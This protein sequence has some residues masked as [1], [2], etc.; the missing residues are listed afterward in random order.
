MAVNLD[1]F[2]FQLSDLTI[3]RYWLSAGVRAVKERDA[4]KGMLVASSGIPGPDDEEALHGKARAEA[5]TERRI[6]EMLVRVSYVFAWACLE[7]LLESC[8]REVLVAE[9]QRVLGIGDWWRDGSLVRRQVLDGW[10]RDQMIEEL[11]R[12]AVDNYRR[13]P[14]PDVPRYFAK[15]LDVPWDREWEERLLTVCRRRNSAAHDLSFTSCHDDLIEKELRWVLD[16]GEAIAR[17]CASKP[18]VSL[19]SET[20]DELRA[21][22]E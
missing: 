13:Q 21:P 11:I 17:A 10:S 20:V 18:G 8:V 14:F 16:C 4:F 3:S 6:R 1:L 2:Y 19:M 7:D 5:R 15:R 9:P 12:R 22:P